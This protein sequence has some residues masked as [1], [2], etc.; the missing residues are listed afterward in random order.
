LIVDVEFARYVFGV[1]VSDIGHGYSRKSE[2][3]T[4]LHIENIR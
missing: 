4:L 3:G 2:G 1:F